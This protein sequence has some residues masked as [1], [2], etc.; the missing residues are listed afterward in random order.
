MKFMEFLENRA[1]IHTK[2]LL[3][4]ASR[5]CGC[6]KVSR[7]NGILC[8]VNMEFCVMLLNPSV[9]NHLVITYA[10]LSMV[11]WVA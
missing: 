9:G 7:S 1:D 4:E 10:Y 8:N 5:R 11:D 3:Y 2:V 6:S